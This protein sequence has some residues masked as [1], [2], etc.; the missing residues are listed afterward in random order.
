VLKTEQPMSDMET[1][2][3]KTLP[4]INPNL[5]VVKF[6]TFN[7]Q[8]SDRFTEELRRLGFGWRWEQSG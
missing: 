2:A 4:A 6:Q 1:I 3:R 8:I 5:T 7:E